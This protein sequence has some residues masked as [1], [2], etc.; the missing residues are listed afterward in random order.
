V[1]V[2]PLSQ[3]FSVQSYHRSEP[4]YTKIPP[5]P[6]TVEILVKIM[7]E[8]LSTLGLVTKQIMQKWPSES[9][10]FLELLHEV[11]ALN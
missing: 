8:L 6:A 11:S 10:P 9:H 3:A 5:T 1:A 7:V 4:I 2:P